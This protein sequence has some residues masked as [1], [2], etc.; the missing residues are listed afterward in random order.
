MF[1]ENIYNDLRLKHIDAEI[2]AETEEESRTAM[3]K[4][5][6]YLD[7]VGMH[8]PKPKYVYDEADRTTW[9]Y[10]NGKVKYDRAINKHRYRSLPNPSFI[11][12][13]L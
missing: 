2:N 10:L 4:V 12:G 5:C 8:M 7:S 3:L 11:Y 6:A 1:D 9:K 13:H